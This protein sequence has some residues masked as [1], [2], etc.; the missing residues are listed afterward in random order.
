M[1]KDKLNIDLN[2]PLVTTNPLFIIACLA[3][4]VLLSW[5]CAWAFRNT[6]D[7][8][9]SIKLYVPLGL[10]AMVVFWLLGLPFLFSAGCVLC[11]FVT[12]MWFSNYY[13]YH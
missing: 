3:V 4:S 2:S 6:N 9:K 7:F 5:I 1:D 10:I 8:L 11:G 13:F 12:M